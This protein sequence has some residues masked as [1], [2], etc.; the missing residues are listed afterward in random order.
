MSKPQPTRRT[1]Q[2]S[3]NAGPSTARPNYFE[4][5][6]PLL[7][8]PLDNTIYV[9]PITI[10]EGGPY[11]SPARNI[12]YGEGISQEIKNEIARLAPFML[13]CIITHMAGIDIQFCH[14]LQRATKL[15][16]VRVLE[17]ISGCLPFQM[18]LNSRLNVVCLRADIH[19]FVDHG[20]ILF[21]PCRDV[22]EALNGLV[23]HNIS[24]TADWEKRHRYDDSKYS[25]LL[26]QPTYKYRVKTGFTEGKTFTHFVYPFTQPELQVVESH[27]HP[28]FVCAHIRQQVDGLLGSLDDAKRA[29]FLKELRYDRDLTFALR[30]TRDWFTQD[31]INIPSDF[32]NAIPP[33]P[34][35]A[36]APDDSSSADDYGKRQRKRFK[37]RKANTEPI[38]NLRQTKSNPGSR[39][40]PSPKRMLSSMKS[41]LCQLETPVTETTRAFKVARD[42][43]AKLSPL[44]TL[45]EVNMNRRTLRSATASVASVPASS[46]ISEHSLSSRAPS[47]SPSQRAADKKGKMR[48]VQ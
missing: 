10:Y 38:P 9:P 26:G 45:K 42:A 28:F 46:N 13:R 44:I 41:I 22:L 3:S 31:N 37:G 6:D 47:P 33:I 8:S 35:G 30:L 32:L 12:N 40:P 4:S 20:G 16:I 25:S 27:I 11:S 18:F 1:S 5:P 34:M 17:W 24:C 19:P 43:L 39:K 36:N 29:E 7:K 21:V 23:I 15:A 14:L 2:R 48:A